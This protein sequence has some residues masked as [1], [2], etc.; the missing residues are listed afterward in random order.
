M[1]AVKALEPLAKADDQALTRLVDALDA[2]TWD[3][4]KTARCIA[5][6]GV[7]CEIPRRDPD[8]G[9]NSKHGDVRAASLLRSKER[10]LLDDPAVQ[11][12]IRRRLEDADA[13][14]RK[15]AFLL[16]VLSKDQLAAVLRASDT[17]LNRQLNE[18][19]KAEK[20]DK[21]APAVPADA[22]SKLTAADYDTL[23]QATASRALD[24][25]LRGAR[26][27]AVLG[28]PRAFGLLLQ[29]SREEDVSRP[30][31]GVP[32][33]RRGSTTSAPV[34]RLRSLLF[35]KEASVRDAAY[36]A[37]AKIFDKTPLS[38]AESG[39]NT[40]DEDVRRR[41]LET[42]IQTIKKKHPKGPG[43]PGWEL[44][45]VA[46]NDGA[47]GV[48]SEAFKSAAQPENR[49]RRTGHAPIRGSGPFTR[50]CAEKRLHRGHRS[51]ER[52]VV[53]AATRRVLQRRRSRPAE[54]G[55]RV[56]DEEEQGDRRS[57][58]RGSNPEYPDARG[59]SR[60]KRLIKK[61]SKAAQQ[62]LLRALGDT[63]R[64]VLYSR[65]GALVDDDAKEPLAQAMTNER[66]DIRVRAAAA[67]AR[68]GDPSTFAVLKGLATE[69][70]P[71]F[72]E[73]RVRLAR[74]HGTGGSAAWANWAT[75]RRSMSSLRS[76]TVRT[77]GSASPPRAALVWVAKADTVSA[78]QAALRSSDPQVKLRAA[79]GLTY[80]GDPTNV[81]LIRS[82][83]SGV[84]SPAEQFTATVALGAAA[85]VQGTVY[86]DSSDEKLRDRALLATL[87]LELKDTDGQPEKCIECVSAKGGRFR[88][89]GAQ[90]LETFS[91]PAAFREFVI[92]EVND[93]GEDTPWKV[94]P[95]VVDD[96]ANLLAF[97]PP[98][99]KAK[100]A[101]LLRFFDNKEQ[102][103]WNAAW[104]VHS[105]R[106]AKEIK[107][108]TA[109]AKKA[110]VPVPSKLTTEQLRELA[111]G[112][113]VG[114]V[115]EQGAS[116]NSQQ[117]A[118]IRQTA[119]SR[120]FAIA[121]KDAKYNRALNRYSRRRWATRTNRCARRRS[122]TCSRSAWTR[123]PSATKPSKPGTPIWA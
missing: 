22:K 15:V 17:E 91:D 73:P 40:A 77:R 33:A 23:L 49:R 70:E 64:E 3:V 102:A 28:D 78:L 57:R 95:E 31:R 87:L 37:L 11:S 98:Q 9:S 54:G 41:G 76:P 58:N 89:T 107:D 119:L 26:G 5:R 82:D 25:C 45:L 122:N 67:L 34:N 1:K 111:F 69:P 96:F 24:T 43:E 63:D 27:L 117:I 53:R 52:G 4:R 14:V 88:L 51:G 110:G 32:R 104:A 6:N 94:A 19:E 7:R 90:A 100:T 109:A 112:G 29:L 18:L 16:S 83:T 50:T 101:L 108:A 12:A 74:C 36:T 47:K 106:F 56:R 48:R 10:W 97:A 39:L 30:R 8:R 120:I 85:G 42:L 92:K 75:R 72:K 71:Q 66:A 80:L 81:P 86:L 55:V 105:V 35:D 38:V 13:G 79:L 20:P 114:L 62:V 103:E 21:A 123:R 118:K 115:R 59:S 84:I 44:L 61:H 60:S 2:A 113:Y 46:L 121:S 68:H 93:R 116:G 99:L 65:S